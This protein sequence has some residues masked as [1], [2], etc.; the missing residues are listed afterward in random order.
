MSVELFEQKQL[1]FQLLFLGQ[2]GFQK[3]KQELIKHQ[4]YGYE[5]QR[6]CKVEGTLFGY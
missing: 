4:L 6:C 3:M 5:K 2:V 1:H